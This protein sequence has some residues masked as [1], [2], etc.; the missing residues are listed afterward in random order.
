VNSSSIAP[1]AQPTLDTVNG[2]SVKELDNQS[3]V[4]AILRSALGVPDGTIAADPDTPLLGA[5]PEMD[6]M[7]VVAILLSIEEQY[8]ITVDD[9]EIDA[10]IFATVGSL[11]VFVESKLG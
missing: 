3:N 11:T 5:I 7:S 4:V 6:S 1:V 2:N 8:G 10:D 9:E